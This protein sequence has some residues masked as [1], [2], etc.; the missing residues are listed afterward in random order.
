MRVSRGGANAN[1]Y[2]YTYGYAYTCPALN[3]GTHSRQ[4]RLLLWP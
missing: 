2:A 4:D 3:P 1:A